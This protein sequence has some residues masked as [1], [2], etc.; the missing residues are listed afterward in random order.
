[1]RKRP[2]VAIVDSGISTSFRYHS[3]IIGGTCF[4][5]EDRSVFAADKYEDSNGHGTMC[6]S[7]IKKYCPEAK[8]YI[9]KVLDDSAKGYSVLLLL[10]LKHLMHT[11]ADIIN[12]SMSTTDTM[13]AAEISDVLTQLRDKGKLVNVSVSNSAESSFPASCSSCFGVRSSEN[14]RSIRFDASAPIQLTVRQF[15]EF[16]EAV[17]SRYVWFGGNSK[18]TAVVSGIAASELQ[19]NSE[20]A[21]TIGIFT[22]FLEANQNTVLLSGTNQ[23]PVPDNIHEALDLCR[24]IFCRY[25]N[26]VSPDLN[27]TLIRENQVMT[28]YS[29]EMILECEQKLGREIPCDRLQY[30]DF[31]DIGHFLTF[32]L[33]PH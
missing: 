22:R 26:I 15:P 1:M 17:S 14:C 19:N 29:Y 9:V 10:A 33:S 27:T 23:Y 18:S 7:V 5:I 30:Q 21:D 28:G 12:V 11:P 13:Y 24:G 2:I 25:L 4:C 6:A 31:T 8:L 32:A 16:A 20:S 3:D